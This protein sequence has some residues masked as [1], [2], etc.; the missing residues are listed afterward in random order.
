VTLLS[1]PLPLH[2][3][4]DLEATCRAILDRML[5]EYRSHGMS[6]DDYEDVLATF[7][8]VAFEWSLKYDPARELDPGQTRISF[9][10]YLNR[11]LGVRLADW[12]RRRH[13]DARYGPPPEVVSLAFELELEAAITARSTLTEAPTTFEEVETRATLFYS[14]IDI[15]AYE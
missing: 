11:Y 15:E 7:I 1:E 14:R 2:D 4:R 3:V 10:T 5:R 8:A 6:P 9:S 13:G 12:F